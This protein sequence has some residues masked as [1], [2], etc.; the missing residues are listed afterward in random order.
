MAEA[1]Q[2][3]L[4]CLVSEPVQFL[5]PNVERVRIAMMYYAVCHAAKNTFTA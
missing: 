4:S 5:G 1:T 2:T 3:W